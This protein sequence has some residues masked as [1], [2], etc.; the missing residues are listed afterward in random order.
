MFVEINYGKSF[1]ACVDRGTQLES[2]TGF[3]KM[4]LTSSITLVSAFSPTIQWVIISLAYLNDFEPPLVS[5]V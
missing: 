4:S 3:S 5:K 1:E 2:T